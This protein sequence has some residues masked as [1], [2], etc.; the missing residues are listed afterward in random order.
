[1][2]TLRATTTRATAT[3]AATPR[4]AT[5][6]RSN[7]V[8]PHQPLVFVESIR[9]YMAHISVFFCIFRPKMPTRRR[10]IETTET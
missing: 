4:R 7:Y 6:A 3:K 2:L 9:I 5:T 10:M 1:M 8:I